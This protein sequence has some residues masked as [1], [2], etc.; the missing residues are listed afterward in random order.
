MDEKN[1]IKARLLE[2]V[3]RNR[4]EGFGPGSFLGKPQV[5]QVR[6]MAFDDL[7]LAEWGCDPE[8]A[9]SRR[10][11]FELSERHMRAVLAFAK[12]RRLTGR[13]A[14]E[15]MVESFVESGQFARLMSQSD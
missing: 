1:D 8:G 3:E 12:R 9:G 4:A 11:R 7:D 10:V 14:L 13:V 5:S 15:W 2:T 6:L